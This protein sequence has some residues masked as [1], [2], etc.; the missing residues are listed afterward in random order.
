MKKIS[1]NKGFTLLE[2]LLVVGIIAILAGIVIIALNPSKQLKTVRDM[3]RKQAI[4]EINKALIQY[5]IANGRYPD[6]ELAIS[7]TIREICNTGSASA[8]TTSVTGETCVSINSVN[9]S[10]LVPD[11]LAAIPVDPSGYIVASGLI[12]TAYAAVGGTG[13]AIA[14]N[15]NNNVYVSA[16]KA[17]LAS[18]KVGSTA[19]VVGLGSNGF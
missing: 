13:Y 2:I 6:M 3:Q 17:E 4:G 14:K 7:T 10:Q 1:K 12:N 5:F 16:P 9:L 11:Y 18:I 19:G 15:S 8:T